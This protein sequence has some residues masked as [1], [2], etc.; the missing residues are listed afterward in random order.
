MANQMDDIKTSL[1]E[2]LE[3]YLYVV[4]GI[5]YR[6]PNDAVKPIRVAITEASTKLN[7]SVGNIDDTVSVLNRMI[8]EIGAV[9]GETLSEDKAEKLLNECCY[10]YSLDLIRLW[11]HSHMLETQVERTY[12]ELLIQ[13]WIEVYVHWIGALVMDGFCKGIE[14]EESEDRPDN[15]IYVPSEMSPSDEP[16]GSSNIN[17]STKSP[18]NADEESND[19][20]EEF[21]KL[22]FSLC[23]QS[24]TWLHLPGWWVMRIRQ[25]INRA[26]A[27]VEQIYMLEPLKTPEGHQV[28]INMLM[29]LGNHLHWPLT[30]DDSEKWLIRNWNYYSDYDYVLE[31]SL[32][33]D[34]KWWGAFVRRIGALAAT[35]LNRK[36][37]AADDAKEAALE[38]EPEELATPGGL[39]ELLPGLNSAT[40]RRLKA[41]FTET[42]SLGSLSQ[43]NRLCLGKILVQERGSLAAYER[44][45][46]GDC[47]LLVSGKRL[48]L[49]NGFNCWPIKE[50]EGFSEGTLLLGK[51]QWE[52]QDHMVRI[53]L[54]DAKE[55]HTH[56]LLCWFGSLDGPLVANVNQTH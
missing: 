19:M 11:G 46:G 26:A 43:C 53:T 2:I 21:E 55:G 35:E 17:D 37:R 44:G 16:F 4:K 24:T 3:Q 36:A 13:A 48:L 22:F 50:D 51:P 49:L 42:Q 54:M 10:H 18:K 20:P 31:A 8:I 47:F 9:F 1:A 32:R 38:S 15:Y 39:R 14:R 28:L 27:A 52:V 33:F 34:G 12:D 41:I 40:I 23:R 5:W 7:R 6:L 45:P 29:E 30:V 25:S 56:I